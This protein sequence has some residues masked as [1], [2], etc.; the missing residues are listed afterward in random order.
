[1]VILFCLFHPPL[2]K[3][4]KLISASLVN[5]CNPGVGSNRRRPSYCNV[6]YLL[7]LRAAKTASKRART[8][9]TK[10]VLFTTI[11]NETYLFRKSLF[12]K[13]THFLQAKFAELG[14][15][16][17]GLQNTFGFPP[18]FYRSR[19]SF[20]RI[21]RRQKLVQMKVQMKVLQIQNNPTAL[22]SFY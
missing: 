2:K 18:D 10:H 6:F 19:N 16:S 12:R 15:V 21:E 1:M 22:M 9:T 14:S 8:P 4:D 5:P 20:C 7:M 11:C 17:W 3:F 13:K